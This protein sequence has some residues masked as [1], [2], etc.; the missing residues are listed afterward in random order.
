MGTSNAGNDDRQLEEC[1]SKPISA[2]CSSLPER[3]AKVP[4]T[5][6]RCMIENSVMNLLSSFT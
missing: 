3:I 2:C 1:Y 5:A 4:P 6:N